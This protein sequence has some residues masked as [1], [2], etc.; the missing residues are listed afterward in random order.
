MR[1]PLAPTG[2]PNATAPP[3]TLTFSL[4]Q[5]P[6]LM[7]VSGTAAKASFTSIKSICAASS[8]AF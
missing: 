7:Q 1:A 4:S 2:W 6:S 3:L 5:P 8:P